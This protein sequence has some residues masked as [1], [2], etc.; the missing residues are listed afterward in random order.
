MKAIR[1]SQYGG[2]DELALH[3]L[4]LPQPGRNE[5]LVKLDYASVNFI[6]V[7]VRQGRY[8]SSHAY[9]NKPPFTLGMEGVGVVEKVGE[10][11]KSLSHGDRVVW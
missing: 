9:R 6:D 3:D 8:K 1:V 11:D 2:S 7:Y 5:V 4:D 10:D